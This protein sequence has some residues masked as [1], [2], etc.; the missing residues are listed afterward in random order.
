MFTT[1]RFFTNKHKRVNK[2]C[3]RTIVLRATHI[4]S[5]M[6]VFGSKDKNHWS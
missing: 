5:T 1:L 2:I 6:T 3:C 4:A